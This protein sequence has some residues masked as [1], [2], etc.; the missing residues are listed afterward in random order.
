VAVVECPYEDQWVSSAHADATAEA[1]RHWDGEDPPEIPERCAGCH[2]T[3][4]FVDYLGADGTAAWVVDS[5]APIGTVI[6]CTACHNPVTAALDSVTFPSGAE[7]TGLG[8]EARCMQCHRGRASST[9]VD[10]AIAEAGVDDDTVSEALSFINIHYYAAAATRYGTMAMGG[11][12]YED[13]TYDARFAHVESFDTCIGCHDP[14]TL[15]LRIEACADCHAGVTSTE[16][17]HSVRAVSSESDYDGDGDT[18]EGIYYEIQ[19]LQAMLYQAIQAYAA[20]VAGTPIVYETHTY[21]YF[22]I[23][24]NADGVADPEEVESG[25]GYSTWTPRLLRAAYNYQVS[26]KDP[27][28]YAH[29]GKYIIQLLYDSIADLNTAL[30]TPIDLTGAQRIDAGHFAGSEEAFRHWDEDGAVSAE[31]ARCHSATGLPVYLADGANTSEPLSNG[32]LCSTCHDDLTAFSLRVVEEVEFPSGLTVHSDT[33]S[34]NLCMTCHQGQQSTASVNAALAGL[35]DDTVAEDLSFGSFNIHYYAAGATLFGTEVQGAYEY[36][37]LTYAGRL[38]HADPPAD[39]VDCH[40]PHGLEVSVEECSPCHRGAAPLE[41]LRLVRVS[42]T[43]YDGDGDTAEGIAGE[44]ATLQEA[45]YAAVQA[46]AAEVAGTP[47]VYEAQIYPYFFIDTNADG[48]TDPDEAD[49]GNQYAAWTARLLRAAYN[50]Q[51]VQK[52]PSTFA[53]NPLYTIQVLH[54]SLQDLAAWSPIDLAATT[55]P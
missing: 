7:I 9:T 4:G 17:L 35:D 40:T 30:T 46:Y 41:D 11:Y 20:E 13:H 19:G 37:G 6:T 33:N 15:E 5:P 49:F 44:I 34:T 25:N 36:A 42:T 12:Q 23:D 22:F 28:A 54:D 2:S 53:H 50:Y 39:C 8:D 16:D 14:H 51:Y 52:D 10:E 43:D 21:P 3:P 38:Q 29:G 24:T 55:R 31:C 47:I 27:G 18:A 1:F 26:V 45:L 48:I 32:L